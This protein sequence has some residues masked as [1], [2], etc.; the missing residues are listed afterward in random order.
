MKKRG[1]SLTR[2]VLKINEL[3]GEN[4]IVKRVNLD[5]KKEIVKLRGEQT[6]AAHV[7]GIAGECLQSRGGGETARLCRIT[8]GNLSPDG[9][10]MSVGANEDSERR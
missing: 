8:A 3:L 5:L 9:C 4:E 10:A 2:D 6:W 1:R 7:L